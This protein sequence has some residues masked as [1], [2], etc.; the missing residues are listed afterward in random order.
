MSDTCSLFPPFGDPWPFCLLP[1][2]VDMCLNNSKVESVRE[3]Q[4]TWV[5]LAFWYSSSVGE[6]LGNCVCAIILFLV[7]LRW[8]VTKG[9]RMP[10]FSLES[11]LFLPQ[12]SALGCWF[13]SFSL[14]TKPFPE[15]ETFSTEL[16]KS[17]T[18]LTWSHPGHS[19]PIYAQKSLANRDQGS[20]LTWI[21]FAKSFM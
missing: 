14:E 16:R 5:L 17:P 6:K 1:S 4:K 15:S 11:Q 7:V 18:Y 20:F 2:Q 12:F 3:F 21:S 19:L 8:C 9:P 10:Q 13:I